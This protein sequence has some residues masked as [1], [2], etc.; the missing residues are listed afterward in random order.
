MQDWDLNLGLSL[1]VLLACLLSLFVC[2]KYSCR[3]IFFFLLYQER[4]MKKERIT[5]EPRIGNDEEI[6]ESG[7]KEGT[8]WMKKGRNRTY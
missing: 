5:E 6:L 2:F 4:E 1:C 7:K 3:N 8:N